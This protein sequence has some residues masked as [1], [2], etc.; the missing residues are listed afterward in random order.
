MI[1]LSDFGSWTQKIRNDY[2]KK[3]REWINNGGWFLVV[4]KDENVLYDNLGDFHKKHNRR[5]VV[6][7]IYNVKEE[8]WTYFRVFKDTGLPEDKDLRLLNQIPAL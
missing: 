5:M 8:Y 6:F 7:D 1:E 4:E 3:S 2:S